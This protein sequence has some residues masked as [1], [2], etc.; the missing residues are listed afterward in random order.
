[1]GDLTEVL[2]LLFLE[3]V[4]QLLDDFVGYRGLFSGLELEKPLVEMVVAFVRVCDE[5]LRRFHLFGVTE[6]VDLVVITR[7]AIGAYYITLYE[8]VDDVTRLARFTLG[9]ING[10]GGSVIK[11]TIILFDFAEIVV[12]YIFSL[13]AF[14]HGC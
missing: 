6:L 4:A 9:C 12:V 8:V 11:I 7:A 2:Y 14:G 5:Y 1:M 3:L 10:F 13:E